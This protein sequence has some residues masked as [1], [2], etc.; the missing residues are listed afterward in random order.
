MYK[1]HT[2]KPSPMTTQ[3][4]KVTKQETHNIQLRKL[5]KQACP[6][7]QY[8]RASCQY[9]DNTHWRKVAAAIPPR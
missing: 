6:L 1:Y 2:P 4:N 9:F 3:T 5:K 8:F 7:A